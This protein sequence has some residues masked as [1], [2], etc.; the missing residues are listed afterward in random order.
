MVLI[1]SRPKKKSLPEEVEDCVCLNLVHLEVLKC[2]FLV[3]FKCLFPILKSELASDLIRKV[4]FHRRKAKKFY[5]VPNYREV[6][7]KVYIYFWL[8]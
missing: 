5:N 6:V 1:V 4:G 2:F 7:Y 3:N 8:D